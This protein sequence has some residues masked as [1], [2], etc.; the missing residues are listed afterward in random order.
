LFQGC[1][2]GVTRS[3]IARNSNMVRSFAVALT[4]ALA[5]APA[6]G[7]TRSDHLQAPPSVFSQGE[8]SRHLCF[9]GGAVR[10]DA[11]WTAIPPAVCTT[12]YDP[13]RVRRGGV[14]RIQAPRGT[15]LVMAGRRPCVRRR[16]QRWA[17]RPVARPGDRL[18]ALTVVYPSGIASW[19]FDVFVKRLAEDG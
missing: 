11:G 2:A 16:A 13:L 15:T 4:F 10:S 1:I 6:A 5:A 7:A 14:I 3:Q 18:M 19:G 12:Q 17:C 9:D 8:R